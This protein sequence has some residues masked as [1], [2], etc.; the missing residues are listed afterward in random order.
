MK[1]FKLSPKQQIIAVAAG[2]ILL[3]IIFIVVLVV[4]QIIKLGDLSAQE[5]VAT[6]E[7]NTAKATYSQLEEL[8]KTSRKTENE[9]LRVD[10]KAPEETELPA[11]LIQIEDISSK[12]GITFMSIKPSEPIQKQDYS[13][14]PLEIQINGYFFSLLDFVY[15]VEKIPRIIN[16]TGIDIKEGKVGLPN[17]EATIKCSAFV[18]TPGIKSGTGGASAAPTGGAAGA[19]TGAAKSASTAPAGGATQ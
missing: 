16:V 18:S 6:N 1:M 19:A 12:A 7:L 2:A 9:L 5:Q 8:K 10:R 15:R 4:P 3:A 13:E 11:L 14:I 17:I